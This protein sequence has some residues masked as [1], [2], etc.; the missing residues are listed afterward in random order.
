M[1]N[2]KKICVITGSRAEYGLL[3][4]VIKLIK[5]ST[6]FK[7]Q[8]IVT[9]THLSFDHGLSYKEIINE[10]FKIDAKVDLK[11]KNNQPIDI[12]NQMGK[13]LVGF[14]KKYK[15]L[16]PDLIILL[17]DRYEILCSSLAAIL[18]KIPIAHIHGGEVTQGSIDNAFRHSIT[19]MSNFHFV[20]T[21]KSKM[22]VI[23][24]GERKENIFNVGSLG[25]ENI[26][27]L[28]L[29]NKDDLEKKLNISFDLSLF[30]ITFHAETLSNTSVDKQIQPLLEALEQVKNVSFLFTSSNSDVGGEIINKKI[31]DF[32]KINKNA[33]FYKN[34]GHLN[35]LSVMK[36]SNAV[37]GNSSS[38]IIEAPSLNVPSINIGDRQFGREKSLSVIDCK[39]T[40]TKI[41]EAIDQILQKKINISN[42]K[43][44]YEKEE[45]SSSILKILKKIDY[46][47][48]EIKSFNDLKF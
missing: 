22:R 17:G 10:G 29:I 16:K 1:K 43:S 31:L 44:P 18:F 37:I 35:Y 12:A 9:G 21:K 46:K 48:I 42:I 45:T 25:V 6:I 8:L 19:K 38:G 14:S 7:L 32:V 27:K 5:K 33:F 34:L 36:Y 30:L 15:K 3:S 20:A 23:Q 39:N 2:N 28:K 13:A 11:I 4:N 47:N 26:K 24:L 40:K 41:M